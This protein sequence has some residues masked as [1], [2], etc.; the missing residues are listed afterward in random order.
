MIYA[1]MCRFLY[2]AIIFAC[3]AGM[4]LLTGCTSG[5]GDKVLVKEREQVEAD[6]AEIE[7]SRA[8]MSCMTLGLAYLEENDL[9]KAEAEFN[10]LILLAPEEASGYANLGIV[11]MRMGKYARAE[12]QLKKGVELNPE[13]PEIRLNLA[14][15]YDLTHKEEASREELEKSLEIEPEHVQALYSL[16]ESY[17][18]NPMIIP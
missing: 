8:I 14:R 1:R 18:D 2:I 12:E 6:G 16:A 3:L 9:E 17:Q 7:K 4:Y 11:Y 13:D 5:S 10:R 15:V